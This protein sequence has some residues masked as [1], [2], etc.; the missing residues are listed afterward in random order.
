MSVHWVKADIAVAS[1][2]TLTRSA[3]DHK[4]VRPLNRPGWGVAKSLELI[5]SGPVVLI[6]TQKVRVQ[7]KKPTCVSYV[8]LMLLSRLGAFERGHSR[9]LG[10]AEDAGLRHFPCVP[11]IFNAE[12]VP[13]TWSF[14][15][16]WKT[17]KIV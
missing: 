8:A 12:T 5:G 7:Y 6:H 10:F 1:V 13:P 15:M 14:L 4:R 3:H 16:T 9:R 2:E 11:T 17:P